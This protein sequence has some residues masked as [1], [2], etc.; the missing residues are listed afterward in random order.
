IHLLFTPNFTSGIFWMGLL[1]GLYLVLLIFEFY[2]LVKDDH[3][4]SRLFGILVLISAVIAHS[5]L[6]AVFGFLVA[7]PYWNGPYMSIYFIVSAFLSGSA[8]LVI[9]FYIFSKVNKTEQLEY[10]GVHVVS[11]LGK[12]MAL[13][14]AITIF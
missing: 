5:N 11:S 9:M 3:K 1:Y 12:L 7:R 8:L 13:F 14:L 10:K 6:G 2:Y 4:K